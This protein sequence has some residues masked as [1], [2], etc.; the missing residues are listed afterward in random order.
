MEQSYL[1]RIIAVLA[2]LAVMTVVALIVSLVATG[3]GQD[4]FQS[5]R[6]VDEIVQKV[7]GAPNNA[8]GLRLNLG[9]DNFFIVIY[10]AYFTVLAARFGSTL[11]A[12]LI[13]VALAAILVTALLDAA[14][15]HH[16]NMMI[17]S[18]QHGL[19]VTVAESQIQMI[20]SN[21]KF[22]ASYLALVLFSIGFLREGGLARVIAW[23]LWLYI[24]VEL[25][26]RVMPVEHSRPFALVRTAFFIASFLLS[27]I[28]FSRSA[29]ARA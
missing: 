23:L 17:H 10:A 21:V 6:H 28:Y 27:A 8:M 1:D 26:S 7:M 3:V 9:L 25:V 13:T 20:A 18:V 12:R 14:E 4:F 2:I 22:H 15:N 5:A 11:D 29:S 16:F 24:L 19:P